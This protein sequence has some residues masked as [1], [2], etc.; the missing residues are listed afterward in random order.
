[1]VNSVKPYQIRIRLLSDRNPAFLIQFR[2]YRSTSIFIPQDHVTRQTILLSA[3]DEGKLIPHFGSSYLT[4]S[5]CG[6]RLTVHHGWSVV[7]EASTNEAQAVL[8]YSSN[9]WP[10]AA[11]SPKFKKLL[12]SANMN[13]VCTG[14]WNRQWCKLQ[15][16][17]EIDFYVEQFK[18]P[19]EKL[20][21]LPPAK[22][23]ETCNDT[24]CVKK[25]LLVLPIAKIEMMKFEVVGVTSQIGMLEWKINHAVEVSRDD[26]YRDKALGLI[27]KLKNLR[28]RL[29]E[30]YNRDYLEDASIVQHMDQIF[31][32]T[33]NPIGEARREELIGI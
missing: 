17:Y 18:A 33:E 5:L 28:E 31:T 19:L 26:N 10:E 14:D 7:G 21:Y 12:S 32:S 27:P 30:L 6:V 25:S 29:H 11:I 24:L 22:V 20:Q 4:I 9:T 2:R 15:D 16:L 8:Y 23:D 13:M 1:M 3:I